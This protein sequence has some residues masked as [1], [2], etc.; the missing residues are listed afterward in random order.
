MLSNNNNQEKEYY[1]QCYCDGIS[2]ACDCE[3]S[4]VCLCA[5][6]RPDKEAQPTNQEPEYELVRSYGHRDGPHEHVENI[7]DGAYGWVYCYFGL[8]P[9][10]EGVYRVGVTHEMPDWLYNARPNEEVNYNYAKYQSYWKTVDK[11]HTLMHKPCMWQLCYAKKIYD[12]PR[13]LAHYFEEF[14]YPEDVYERYDP[15]HPDIIDVKEL[16]MALHFGHF[17][18]HFDQFNGHW[19]DTNGE[20][21][22]HETKPQEEKTQLH[23]DYNSIY[24]SYSNYEYSFGGCPEEANKHQFKTMEKPNTPEFF[25]CT[26]CNT[27][28]DMT[29]ASERQKR[30][31]ENVDF[32]YCEDCYAEYRMCRNIGRCEPEDHDRLKVTQFIPP[33]YPTKQVINH[34][35]GQDLCDCMINGNTAV[36]N[37]LDNTIKF[38]NKT[39]YTLADY[40][41]AHAKMCHPFLIQKVQK[42]INE[43]TDAQNEKYKDLP[44]YT[45]KKHI[46]LEDISQDTFLYYTEPTEKNVAF[47]M[48]SSGMFVSYKSL[49]YQGAPSVPEDRVG[50]DM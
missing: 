49:P 48:K 46:E 36:Y 9:K 10:W 5:C 20:L 7:E 22:Y 31:K 37:W 16:T 43:E 38:N 45:P 23:Q 34:T 21:H 12:A 29:T 26:V 15:S 42:K 3:C 28:V 24:H 27:I 17:Q 19:I 40:V 1:G 47:L 32:S 30:I 39:Y 6:E 14:N 33:H 44:Y 13:V 50:R 25:M 11:T 35:I 2:C 41:Y 18:S 8:D 4:C